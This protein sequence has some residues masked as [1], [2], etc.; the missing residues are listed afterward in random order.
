CAE[1]LRERGGDVALKDVEA[2]QD[3]PA[4]LA[5]IEEEAFR[6]K[7]I[8]GSLLQFVR[9]PGGRRSSADL[10][11]LVEKVIDLLRRQ[12]RFAHS[13]MRTEL[14]PEL[15]L[16][17]VNEGQLRQVFLGI[18][19]NALEATSGE[20]PLTV[21]TCRCQP[22]EVTVEFIDEGPGIPEDVVPRV[23]DP[24]FTTKPPGQGTG[25]G[26]AIAQGIVTEHGGRIELVSRLGVGTTFRVV[27]PAPATAAV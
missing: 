12:S 3:F 10:N 16:L 7:E 1:S 21:R 15:P 22:E 19:A 6:C 20:G 24:F 8:T 11:G 25:L 17:V 4:Y 14:D 2:F 23:F 5:I 13:R 27:L 9:E 26:L 18:S